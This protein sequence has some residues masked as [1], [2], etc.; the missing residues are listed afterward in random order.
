MSDQ[1]WTTSSRRALLQG[2]VLAAVAAVGG[3]VAFRA[4]TAPA[5]S[6]ASPYGPAAGGGAKVIVPLADVPVGGGVVV[7]GPQV[8]VVRDRSGG[9]HGF[10]AVC[11]HQG[12]LVSQ[13]RDGLIRC[14]CHGSAFD[15]TTGAVAQGPATLPLP[16]VALRVQGAD[17]VAG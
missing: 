5:L 2:G 1:S 3:F 14:P 8:V 16:E 7:D 9:V 15:A 10:S 17:V 11:T 6:G 12:C 4:R 13:V